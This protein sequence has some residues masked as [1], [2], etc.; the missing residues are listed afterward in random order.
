MADLITAQLRAEGF[1][2]MRAATA[3]EGLVRAAKRRPQLITLDIFLPEMDGWEFM[4]RLKADPKLAD[5][6]VVIITIS[7]DLDRSLA[8]G[9]RR[10]LQ[11]PFGREGLVAALAGLVD[12]RPGGEPARVLVVDDNVKAVELTATVLE[13]EGYRV[14]RAY[15]GAEAIE[16]AR[17]AHPDL[18]ILDLMMPQVSGF[19]VARALRES[20]Q[21]ARIPILVLTA[22]DL[23]AED[24]ERLNGAVNA[25]LAKSS[26]S[27]SELLAELRRALPKRGED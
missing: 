20:E 16:V 27:T 17:S 6:P 25:I 19:E 2:V 3:E 5:T 4:R 9:A 13:A 1:Q 7:E 15:G 10:V 18:L 11:K 23:S 8:L 24:R 12:A 26:F 14:L 22:K 21:T